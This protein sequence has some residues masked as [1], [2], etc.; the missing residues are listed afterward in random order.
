MPLVKLKGL[1]ASRVRRRACLCHLLESALRSRAVASTGRCRAWR[2]VAALVAA[3]LAFHIQ[4]AAPPLLAQ[5]QSDEARRRLEQVQ[6]T[7]RQKKAAEQ[8]IAAD[9]SQIQ[10]ERERLGASLVDTARRI[11]LSEGQLTAIEGRLGE[12]EAQERLLRGS[13]A[14]RHG[15]IARLL[16]AMQRMGRDPPPVMI[17]RREDALVMVRSAMMLATAFPQLKTQALALAGRLEELGR[18]M[19][20]IRS[21]GDRLRA[22]TQRLSQARTQLSELIELR[23][24]SLAE[25][26]GA[27]EKVRKEAAEIARNV[28]DL[29]ELIDKLDKVVAK[30]ASEAGVAKVTES[31]AIAA[32]PPIQGHEA[33]KAATP[34]DTQVPGAVV[35]APKDQKLA[36]LNQPRIKAAIPFA[37]A[38]GR[39][40]LPVQGKRIIGFGDKAHTNKSNGI[41][42]E[43]R[44]G[45][46]VVSPADGWI[47]FAGVFRSYGQIL[48]INGGDGYHMLLAGLSQIDVQLGQFVLAGE[49]VGLMSGAAQGA[50]SQQAANAPVLYIE[51][52]KDGRSIDPDPWWAGESTQKV[53]G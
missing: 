26:Q 14:E 25:R 31:G 51:L 32:P 7:L 52:R 30:Q 2:G 23:R 40:P 34:T 27:L 13:L 9:L 8:G 1:D 48:I 29:N 50:K 42:I 43:T 3:L 47:V 21:E 11:Q 24:Q 44:P 35:L 19:G 17:T 33:A 37:Q 49:P 16:G 18:V 46:Q 45:A 4:L 22:E 12:L 6:E 5:S 28:T 36:S 15:S 39:L 53:Q 38:R 41:V 10:A 20:D